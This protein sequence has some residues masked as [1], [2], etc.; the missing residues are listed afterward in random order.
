MILLDIINL[1]N[2][3]FIE[4]QELY[5][6]FINNYIDIHKNNTFTSDSNKHDDLI[7]E[8]IFDENIYKNN[9]I[10]KKIKIIKNIGEGS[11]G[12]VYKIKIDSNYYALKINKNELPDK[13]KERYN[14]LI[15]CNVLKKYVIK[16]FIAGE[17]INNDDYK[18][19]S[20]M[21]YG[22]NS[23]RNIYEKFDENKT[24]LVIK[25]LFNIINITSKFKFLMTDFK[26]SNITCTSDYKIK[27][28][29]IYMFC[30]TYI[31]CSKCKIV[32]TYSTIE[33]EY[34]K[35]IYEDPNYNFT[36]IYI[37]FAICIID[38]ICENTMYD[39][40]KKISQK[41]ELNIG[42]K[43]IIPLLQI[44]CYNFNNKT[45]KYIREYKNLYNYKKLTELTYPIIKNDNLYDYF[46]NL[47]K[48][49]HEF[50]SKKKFILI[51][52]DLINLDPK[53]RSLKYLKDKLT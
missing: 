29:D 8:N 33:I 44:S 31:P 2:I 25:Q 14:S 22:G 43:N 17:I 10:K 9:S 38:L 26:L 41:F 12:I 24:K 52:N 32:R 7:N 11:Y 53:Q 6:R 36:C 49:K 37:P 1:D 20:I 47:I 39:Y 4:G 27:L 18:Y 21:E 16:I 5:I 45:N 51:L 15:S 28:I 3:N 23:L 19:F 42:I 46:V 30:E 13:L 40:C 34:E 35:R 50:I 48:I